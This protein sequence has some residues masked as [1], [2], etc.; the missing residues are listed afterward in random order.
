MADVL[1]IPPDQ[2][3]LGTDDDAN[4]RHFAEDLDVLVLIGPEVR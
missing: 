1:G 3:A 4:W 2:I